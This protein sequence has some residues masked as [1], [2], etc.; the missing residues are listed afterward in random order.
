MPDLRTR[1]RGGKKI[2]R[3][4]A[5]LTAVKE[6]IL[7]APQCV[8]PGIKLTLEPIDHERIKPGETVLIDELIKP[9]LA[10]DEEVRSPHAVS[11]IESQEVFHPGGKMIR[12]LALEFERFAVGPF[13]D[14]AFVQ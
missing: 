10:P 1:G 4:V 5:H 11:D 14:D 2:C 8:Q 3:K 9:I 13:V 6:G 12:G 7:P